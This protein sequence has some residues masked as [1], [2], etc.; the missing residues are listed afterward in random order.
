[1]RGRVVCLVVLA[2][3]AFGSMCLVYFASA[4]Q[5]SA[6][7]HYAKWKNGPPSDPN[8][9]P[10]GVWLQDPKNAARYKELGINMYVGLWKGPTEE[11]LAALKAAGMKVIC[12]QNEVGLRH[13]DD[14][15]IIGW[16]QMDEPDNAQPKEGGG[17]GPA[18]PPEKVIAEYERMKRNDPTRPVLLNLGQGVANDVWVGRGCKWWDYYDYVRG[19]D[20]ISF[21]IYPVN[22]MARFYK[23]RDGADCIWVVYKGVWRLREMVYDQKPVWNVIETVRI[24]NNSGT[25]TPEHIRAEVWMSIIAGSRGIFYFCHQFEPK[26][27]EA[28]PLAYPQIGAA[29]KRING[30]LRQLAPVI[31][32][33]D[34]GEIATVESPAEAPVV[35]MARRYRGA[36]YIFAVN[37][38]KLATQAQLTIMGEKGRA[39]VE[40]IG[41]GR[42]L[43]AR[44]GRFS[45]E[46]DGYAVHLYRYA[47]GR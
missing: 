4:L 45:D 41:E 22:S 47:G 20:I 35:M 8:F 29:L 2:A 26:F 14:P 25:P 28:G 34:Q 6:L 27:I 17:W 39:K 13:L 32:T 19:C 7:R 12:A 24:R 43:T 9:F 33:P 21:D 15:T 3:F 16:L 44:D 40:V 30:E 11:Q 23:T 38:R 37:T 46:F 42:S 36:T 5:A 18:V 31:N 1:M 10:I